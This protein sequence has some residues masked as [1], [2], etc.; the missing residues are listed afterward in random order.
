MILSLRTLLLGLTMLAI[1]AVTLVEQVLEFRQRLREGQE[2]TAAQ[3]RLLTSAGAPLL[4]SSLVVGDLATVEQ[5]LRNINRDFAW[6]E[7]KLYEPDGRRLIL[8]ATPPFVLESSAPSW[9]RRLLGP[10]PG[11]TRIEL[12]ADPVVYAVL[13]VTPSSRNLEN[14]LWQG[15]G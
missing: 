5:T 11:E 12:A 4:V 9:F 8:D 7:V 14:A 1:L 6:R 3:T 15:L 13:A 2:Q 10:P